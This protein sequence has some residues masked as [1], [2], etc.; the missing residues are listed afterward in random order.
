MLQPAAA[1]PAQPAA[2]PAQ[3]PAQPSASAGS[4]ENLFAVRIAG[5]YM[6]QG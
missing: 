1:A 6:E 3:A 2:P 4:A 5:W